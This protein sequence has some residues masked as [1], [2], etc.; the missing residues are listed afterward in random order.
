M[1]SPALGV[2]VLSKNQHFKLIYERYPHIGER[3]KL[4]WG[5]RECNVYM[6]ELF[7]DTRGATRQGFPVE[8]ASALFKLMQEHEYRFPGKRVVVHDIWNLN[9]K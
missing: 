7:N 3:I 5:E 8:I 1:N 2:G 9:N 4:M 6:S